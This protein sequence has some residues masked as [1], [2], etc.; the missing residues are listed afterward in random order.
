M[1]LAWDNLEDRSYRAGLDRGVLYTYSAGEY[2]DGVPWNGLTSVSDKP[3]GKEKTS[4][5]TNDV[6]KNVEL[7]FEEYGGEVKCYMY[8]DEF[9]KCI[10]G[11]MLAPGIYA[12]QQ[13]VVPFG[14]SY[15][16]N[17]GNMFDGIDFGYEIHMV[18]NAIIVNTLTADH[19][20]LGGSISPEEMSFPFIS[21]PYEVD[22]FNPIAHV[23]ANSRKLGSAL[24]GELEDILYGTPVTYPRLPLPE[25]IIRMFND[26]GSIYLYPAKNLY[27][28]TSTYPGRKNMEVN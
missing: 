15:R 14:I 7:S 18:Y 22:G 28:A 2:V 9:E 4:L 16:T 12:Y 3:S 1:R 19:K 25:E 23:V 10:G 13:Q 11:Q 20:T 17:I 8:P 5:Y 24:T 26:N 6:L 27:P 21:I